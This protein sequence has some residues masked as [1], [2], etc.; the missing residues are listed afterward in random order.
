MIGFTFHETMSGNCTREGEQRAFS[1]HVDVRSGSVLQYLTDR[2]ATLSG[3][4]D[5][6]GL[7]N[8][9]VLVGT[10]VIDPLL[11]RL[12]R[13]EFGFTGDDGRPYRYAGQKD[14]E[15]RHPFD[16]M[17]TLPGEITDDKG[18]LWA[19]ALV[20]FDKRDLP[21]FLRSFRPLR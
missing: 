4:V 17:T 9:A 5:I 16:S 12:I 19:R 1:F 21:S 8:H 10:I 11:G 6:E 3:H 20:H 7:A 2:T 14:V 18:Q 13:Y 15:P